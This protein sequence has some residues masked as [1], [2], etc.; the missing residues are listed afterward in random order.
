LG[1]HFLGDFDLLEVG[2]SEEHA[3]LGFEGGLEVEEVIVLHFVVGRVR[4]GMV[5]D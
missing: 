4:H 3:L 1:L 2:D 5:D